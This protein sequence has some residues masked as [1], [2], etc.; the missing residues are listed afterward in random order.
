[1]LQLFRESDRGTAGDGREDGLPP[2]VAIAA[3]AAAG[4]VLAVTN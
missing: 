1:V 3:V 4:D 2:L